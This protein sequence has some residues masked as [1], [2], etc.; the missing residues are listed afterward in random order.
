VI[1][2]SEFRVDFEG[3]VDRERIEVRIT[4][5]FV[6]KLFLGWIDAE[7]RLNSVLYLGSVFDL[8]VQPAIFSREDDH[9][10]LILTL[11]AHIIKKFGHWF[12]H[13]VIEAGGSWVEN[14]VLQYDP[15][16]FLLLP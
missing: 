2:A 3:Q 11:L 16:L 6:V 9:E 8:L 5:S 4:Y 7:Y 10:E 13:E 14:R 15:E 12:S 1:E